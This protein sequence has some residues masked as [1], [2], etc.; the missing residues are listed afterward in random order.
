MTA[1]AA[2]VLDDSPEGRSLVVTG[3]WSAEAAEVLERGEADGLVLNYA[4]GFSERHLDFLDDGLRVRRLDVLDRQITDL[5]PIQRLAESLEDLSIQAAPD[6]ELDLG[7]LPHLRSVAGE[8]ALIGGTLSAVDELQS[9]ITW[10]FDEVDLHS[11]RDHVGLQRLTIKEA[12]Y[13]ESLSGVAEMGELAALSILLARRLVDIGDLAGLAP[14]LRRLE[15]QDCPA[16]STLDDVGSLVNL[17]FLGISE[18]GDID[19]LAPVTSLEHLETF[20]AWGSTRVIDGDLSP[21]AQLPRLK[22]VRMRNRRAYSPRVA[23][24]VPVPPA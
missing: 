12:P 1:G 6:A 24:V 18:C 19:S 8:W 16:I 23:D 20:Y 7:E 13:L 14:S 9:V 3:S 2:Y 10:Q 21:L 5:A 11:F 4:R 22:E 17:R 15:L